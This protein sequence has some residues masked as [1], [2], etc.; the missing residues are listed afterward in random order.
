MFVLYKKKLHSPKKIRYLHWRCLLSGFS[1]DLRTN[2]IWKWQPSILWWI[3]KERT[4]CLESEHWA[5]CPHQKTRIICPTWSRFK[6]KHSFSKRKRRTFTIRSY[7]SSIASI[8]FIFLQSQFWSL[9]S[10]TTRIQYNNFQNYFVA[11]T[12]KRKFIDLKKKKTKI[13][14]N[15]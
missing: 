8:L 6:S 4:N 7:H 11:F 2:D 10:A 15:K 9:Y 1:Y 13:K 14:W 12:T 3:E 5:K